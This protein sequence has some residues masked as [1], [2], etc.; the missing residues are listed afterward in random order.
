MGL[1]NGG[2]RYVMGFGRNTNKRI[3]DDVF[4]KKM[5]PPNGGR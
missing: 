2:G 5:G 1:R 3:K 4:S